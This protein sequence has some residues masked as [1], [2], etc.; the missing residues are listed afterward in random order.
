M[1][2]WAQATTVATIWPRFMSTNGLNALVT[3]WCTIFA[4]LRLLACYWSIHTLS[5]C[6]DIKNF[7]ARAQ[8]WNNVWRCAVEYIRRLETCNKKKKTRSY[9]IL[10]QKLSSH[11]D[12]P[13][14][15]YLA[16]HWGIFTQP[17][18]PPLLNTSRFISPAKLMEFGY[19]GERSQ[20]QI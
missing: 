10:I 3:V 15:V 9:F 14:L 11:T 17:P 16:F 18:L 7:V 20:D 8:L 1:Q 2:S 19:W 12:L 5:C 6:R 13:P 4:F